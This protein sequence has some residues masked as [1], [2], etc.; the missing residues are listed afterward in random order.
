MATKY[1]SPHHSPDDPGGVIRE[2]LLMGPEFPGPAE[3]VIVAWTL[4][5]GVDRDPADSAKR[6]LATYELA[7]G[8][9]PDGA[10]GK[11]VDLLRQA[12]GS[13]DLAAGRPVR[14]VRRGGRRRGQEN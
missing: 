11:L 10:C 9:L 8:P 6:L 1:L 2:V 13:R 14:P 5:L 3:D 12:A 7:E 4:R